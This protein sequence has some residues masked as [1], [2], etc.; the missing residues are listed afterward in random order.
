MMSALGCSSD[1]GRR[2]GSRQQSRYAR[3]ICAT[4]WLLCIPSHAPQYKLR[5]FDY[6]L[7]YFRKCHF[8]YDFFLHYNFKFPLAMPFY[9]YTPPP[10]LLLISGQAICFALMT[11][12]Y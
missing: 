5:A 3:Q 4:L 12:G 11:L 7:R 1:Y 2:R 8:R 6:I 9:K 10:H